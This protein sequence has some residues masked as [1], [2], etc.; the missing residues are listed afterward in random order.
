MR[1]GLSQE[2]AAEAIGLTGRTFRNWKHAPEGDG[3]LDRK[4]F[5][6]PLQYAKEEKDR[7]IERFCQLDVCDLSLPQAFYKLLDEEGLY[8]CSLSTLYRIFRE[9]K[10]M[11]KRSLHARRACAPSRRPT[12]PASPTRSGHGTSPT[13]E[14]A[15]TQGCFIMHT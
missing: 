12:A 13:C 7:I 2:K 8:L 11:G 1:L 14:R 3:R 10:L 9:A 15:A 5:T 4:D 6:S